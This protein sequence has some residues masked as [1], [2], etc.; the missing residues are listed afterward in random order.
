M[1]EDDRSW[2]GT[3]PGDVDRAGNVNGTE[4]AEW[5]LAPSSCWLT[6]GEQAP[7]DQ[8]EVE[9]ESFSLVPST[10]RVLAGWKGL[11]EAGPRGCGEVAAFPAVGVN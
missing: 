7:D 1:D 9:F 6:T 10:E 8:V 5:S 4:E 3:P 11:G 2:P